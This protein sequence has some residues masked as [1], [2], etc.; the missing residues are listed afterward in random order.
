MCFDGFGGDAEVEG[1]LAIGVVETEQSGY[2]LF[3]LGEALPILQG[4]VSD[5]TIQ[6]S[7]IEQIG[8]QILWGALFALGLFL[9]ILHEVFIQFKS[10]LRRTG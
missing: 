9:E 7:L 2:F 3:A 10:A 1:D 5:T 4:L 6:E 8:D